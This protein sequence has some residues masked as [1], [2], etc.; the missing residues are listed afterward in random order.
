MKIQALALV[1]LASISCLPAPA[2]RYAID[3]YKVSGGGGTS[4]N[5]QYLVR[6]TAGQPDASGAMTRGRYA[7]IGGFWRPVSNVLP[8]EA[9]PVLTWTSPA[10]ITYGMAL[11]PGQLNATA[12]VPGAFAYT[13]A[14]GAILGAGTSSLS[15]IFTPNDLV[16]YSWATDTV[17][18]VV[19]PAALTVTAASTN[20]LYG[21]PNTAFQG[22]IAGVVNGDDITATYSCSATTNSPAGT[23]AIVPGLND[24][25]GRQTNYTVNLVDGTLTVEQAPVTI[26]W[27]EPA[28]VAYGTAL[29][30]IQLDAMA[31]VPGTYAYQPPAGAQL[32]PGA[33]T[34][35]VTFT[36]AD[37]VDY[38]GATDSVSLV[39]T[40]P[41]QN[42][43]ETDEPLLPR[44]AA[45]GL[46]AGLAVGGAGFLARRR[47]QAG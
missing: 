25:A 46:A 44:W 12:N 30:A 2:Q 4:T 41:T 36:P 7:V 39:V 32:N 18:L 1:F 17:S 37:P 33:N 20:R 29:S 16:D 34:L 43:G 47:T 14:A 21:Q 13:P 26:V 5:G 9:T 35:F 24:P 27:N 19:Q 45:A 28:P 22:T 40:A 3:W 15:V 8:I 38:T 10:P 31:T 11:G 23:Y 6:G 42:T